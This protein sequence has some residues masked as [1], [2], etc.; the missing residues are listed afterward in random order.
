[1][2]DYG[3]PSAAQAFPTEHESL[4]LRSASDIKRIARDFSHNMKRV[5]GMGTLPIKLVALATLNEAAR[6]QALVNLGLPIIGSSSIIN[7]DQEIRQ[8]LIEE[9]ERVV[10]ELSKHW[11]DFNTF[12]TTVGVAG[13]NALL[14]GK[15][16]E[17]K[18]S[19]QATL[20]AMLIGLW[21]AFESQAQDVWVLAVNAH[22]K[23]LADRV[24]NTLSKDEHQK[25]VS[26]KIL[27]DADYNLQNCMGDILLRKRTVDFQTLEN[28]RDAYNTAFEKKFD[29]IFSEH[30]KSFQNSKR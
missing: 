5:Y 26:G 10:N 16:E 21:T 8:K 13:L 24:L 30:L 29:G 12:G 18:D 11:P 17:Y 23:P 14:A 15:K 6:V 2:E 25:F 19:I 28:I 20:A 1:M 4:S 22:R 3:F 27:S 7:Q 9:R